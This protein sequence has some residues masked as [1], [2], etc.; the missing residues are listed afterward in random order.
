MQRIIG[1]AAFVMVLV[2]CALGLQANAGEEEAAARLDWMVKAYGDGRHNAFTDL[3]Q[4]KNMYYL[5]FR[6]G[7]A[8]GSIDGEIRV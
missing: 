1:A 6:H 8:H 7:E 3:I 4:W 2:V 5:C